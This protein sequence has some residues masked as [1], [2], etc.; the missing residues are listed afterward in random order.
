MGAQKEKH[1][2]LSIKN[3]RLWAKEKQRKRHDE[4]MKERKSKDNEKEAKSCDKE[5][6]TYGT[7]I[8]PAVEV[9]NEIEINQDTTCVDTNRDELLKAFCGFRMKLEHLFQ[10][11]KVKKQVA[12]SFW[13]NI[14]C[15][16]RN[17]KDN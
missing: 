5:L 10:N 12:K 4:I 9:A 11:E 8:F 3:S 6:R 13:P 7:V 16:E 1:N 17:D 15:K 2:D 14:C